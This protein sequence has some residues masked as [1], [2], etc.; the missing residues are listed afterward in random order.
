MSATLVST[1]A[2]ISPRRPVDAAMRALRALARCANAWRERRRRT[3]ADRDLLASM[4]D[5]E[6][7]DI[8]ITRTTLPGMERGRTC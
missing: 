2:A 4:S 7:H 3:A 5:R 1:R 8:G 6:L